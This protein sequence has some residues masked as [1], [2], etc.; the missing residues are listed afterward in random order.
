MRSRENSSRRQMNED[1]WSTQTVAK[2]RA[3]SIDVKK[4]TI[5]T[6]AACDSTTKLGA[7]ANYQNF[8][9]STSNRF[10]ALAAEEVDSQPTPQVQKA[11][12]GGQHNKGSNDGGRFYNFTT[13]ASAQ[14]QSTQH[15]AKVN[16]SFKKFMQFK[17]FNGFILFICRYDH[18]NHPRNVKYS[19]DRRVVC[20]QQHRLGIRTV[21]VAANKS[22]LM[23]QRRL[24]RTSK[25]K[26][27]LRKR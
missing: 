17:Y 6:G 8:M 4:I 5:T 23:H 26:R 13:A 7:A 10:N 9:S 1:G 27:P 15:T 3:P 14:Q 16:I 11:P 20:N 24:K 19:V 21:A 2:G 18:A 12:Q 22:W 25:P